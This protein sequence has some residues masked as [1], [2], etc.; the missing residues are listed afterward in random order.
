MPTVSGPIAPNSWRV[1]RTRALPPGASAMTVWP[2]VLVHPDVPDRDMASLLK[3]ESVH[4]R[5]QR[6]WLLLPWYL[7]YLFFL[8]VGWNPFRARWERDAYRAQGHSDRSI[9]AKLKK[10]PYYLWWKQ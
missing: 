9:T 6:H 4:L 7:L 8:P 2:V 10:A 1:I 5:Q 3:H